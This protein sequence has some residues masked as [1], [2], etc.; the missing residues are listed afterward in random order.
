MFIFLF[1]D[2]DLDPTFNSISLLLHCH[3]MVKQRRNKEPPEKYESVALVVGVTG[4]VGTSLAEILPL[5]DTPG[6]PWKVYGVARRARPAWLGDG[7]LTYVQCD[8][9]DAGQA[10]ERLSALTD[11]THVFY[12]TWSSRP[13]EAE[14]CQVNG[15]MLKNVLDAVI[16]NA[17]NLRHVCLQTGGKHYTGP[18]DL[19]ARVIL[20]LLF[21]RPLK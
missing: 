8:V 10:R 21:I 3:E 4:I 9:S 2:L 13:T 5:A 17:P 7:P 15:A 6:G 20:I 12:V 11:V 14:N 18:F 19:M 1:L 16:A